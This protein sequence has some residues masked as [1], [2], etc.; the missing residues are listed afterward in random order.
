[1]STSKLCGR[2]YQKGLWSKSERA[3]PQVG[4]RLHRNACNRADIGYCKRLRH[5]NLKKTEKWAWQVNQEYI[6]KH[7][8]TEANIVSS[9]QIDLDSAE[10]DEMWSFVHDK[11]QQYWLWWAVDHRTGKPLAYCFGT[12]EHK[13]L[14][15]LRALLAPFHIDTIYADDNYA[16]KKHITESTVVTG[17]RNTQR[18]ERNH[19]SLRT[20]CSR[21]VRKGIRFSKSHLMHRIVIGLII[22]CRFWDRP[23]PVHLL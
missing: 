13:H 15:E 17:K 14:D 7:Q 3:G 21:L 11:S 22:N 18:I 1:M 20:W 8:V 9:E 23:L 19:L 2:I 4:R 10:M 6:Q 16:Y 12:R 5:L